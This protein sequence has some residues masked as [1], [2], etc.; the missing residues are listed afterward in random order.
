MPFIWTL[1]GRNVTLTIKGE[2]G[3]NDVELKGTFDGKTLT[4]NFNSRKVE[5]KKK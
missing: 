5:F 4:L 3:E 1:E 2:N